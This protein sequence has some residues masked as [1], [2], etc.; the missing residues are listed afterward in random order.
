MS[1]VIWDEQI[2]Q[3]IEENIF[4]LYLD[5]FLF[6]IEKGRSLKVI[7]LFCKKGHIRYKKIDIMLIKKCRYESVKM[8]LQNMKWVAKLRTVP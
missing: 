3:T 1:Y 8:L 7:F 2:Q 6:L 5:P 4:L